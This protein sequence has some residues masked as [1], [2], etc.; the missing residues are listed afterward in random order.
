MQE[1]HISVF[2]MVMCLSDALDLI[3]PALVNHHKRVA[4]IADSIARELGMPE[5]E[6]VNLL[7]AGA[8]HDTGA[9]SLKERLD[10]LQFEIAEPLKHAEQGYVLLKRFK[11]FQKMSAIVRFHHTYWERGRGEEFQNMKVPLA[12]HIL[13][14]ADRVSVLLS[15]N[16]I[17][18][19]VRNIRDNINKHKGTMFVPE[20]VEAF[21]NISARECFWLD[22]ISPYLTDIL[23]RRAPTHYVELKGELLFQLAK[24]FSRVIDFRSRFTATHSSGVAAC[25]S[26][27]ARLAGFSEKEC[28][29]IEISG[30]LHDLGKL[31]VPPEILE[32]PSKL[33]SNEF[34][35]IKSHTYYT[36]RVLETIP[37]LKEIN[38]W[39]SFHHE[40]LD[41]RGYP[42]HCKSD[43]LSLGSRI[44]SVADVFT[45]ITEDRPY[46]KGMGSNEARRV[47]QQMAGGALDPYIVSILNSNFN[48]VDEARRAAQ[49]AAEREYERL[50]N[51][52][53]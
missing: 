51:E 6:R 48:K 32:K 50:R 17:L 3:S 43:E 9:L 31:A 40:R 5:E 16:N 24:L 25:A 18:G 21:D 36:F 33:N 8:L 27:L 28:L 34:N 42:F 30:Y 4:Y 47:L 52:M 13:H 12:S 2:D 38:T 10:A 22:C 29:M 37:G 49:L 11:P 20:L 1:D 26:V 15:E 46:R 19:Q 53:E 35:Q 7:L 39:A 45:A 41:G 23:A 44:L 14:L